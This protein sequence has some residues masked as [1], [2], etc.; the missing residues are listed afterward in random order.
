MRDEHRQDYDEGRGG[1]GARVREDEMREQ[2]QKEVY[3]GTL[4]VPLGS[5]TYYS[6]Y[7][8]TKRD[9]EEDD[10]GRNIRFRDSP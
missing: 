5:N 6:S 4:S 9:R 10:Y 7:S 2:N 3:D 1:W 8:S